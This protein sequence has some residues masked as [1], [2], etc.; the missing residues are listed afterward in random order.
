MENNEL[1]KRIFENVRN[2]IVVSNLESE[3]NMKINK[4]KQILS[5]VTVM[6]IMFTGSFFTVNAATD[7]KVV[8]EIKKVIT[9]TYD[10]SKYKVVT[11]NQIENIDGQ[12]YV[13]YDI[14]SNDGT[15]EFTTLINK[16]EIDKQNLQTEFN[17]I[18][19]KT[20]N[21]VESSVDVVISDEKK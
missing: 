14:I 4:R 11:E 13:K 3:E 10:Q 21:E 7:G 17:I 9:I 16:S 8:E 12:E 6:F 19:T 20:D 5:V 15:E 2:R 1:N 18:S